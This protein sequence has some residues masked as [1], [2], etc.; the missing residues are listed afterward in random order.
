MTIIRT[1]QPADKE[2]VLAMME[3]FYTSPAV[4]TN[5]SAT[6]YSNDFEACVS[7]NPYLEGY[8]FEENG[9]IQ[10]YAMT[11]KS[12]STEFGRP[13]I[14][15]EDIYIK[16]AFRGTGVGSQFLKFIGNMYPEAVL[17]LEVEE[18]NG[19]AVK[20]YEKNGFN[21]LPYMEMKKL[22]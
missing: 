21:V 18:E 5:G 15:L 22:L 9:Q 10:G 4:F 1:M 3:V 12:F 8:M 2:A 6:I 19:R 20:V 13:C 14:W 16:E 11:A 7:D 17:R